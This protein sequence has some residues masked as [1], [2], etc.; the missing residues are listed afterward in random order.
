MSHNI[1]IESM[2]RRVH[3]N[4][5]NQIVA[6]IKTKIRSLFGNIKA[7]SKKSDIEFDLTIE[8]LF[9]LMDKSYGSQCKYCDTILHYKNM[10]C[11][12]IVPVVLGGPSTKTNMQFICKS[13]NTRK[14][15]LKEEEFIRL[16]QLINSFNEIS[17][18]HLLKQLAKGGRF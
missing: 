10:V 4:K 9:A 6:K 14:G 12:H 13:C 3:K 8:E 11:D 5:I 2:A 16:L 18:N 15:P 7:R 17:R 1:D